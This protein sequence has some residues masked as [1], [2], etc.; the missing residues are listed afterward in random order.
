MEEKTELIHGFHFQFLLEFEAW[1]PSVV[2]QKLPADIKPCISYIKFL[3]GKS[4]VRHQ[5]KKSRRKFY[6]WGHY[7][8]YTFSRKT[9]TSPE[10]PEES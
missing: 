6:C 9:T 5:Q 1:L 2:K 8:K 10:I 4:I 3:F 7:Q